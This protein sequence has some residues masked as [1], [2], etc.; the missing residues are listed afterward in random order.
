MRTSL[1]IYENRRKSMKILLKSMKI[2]E[3]LRK[4]LKVGEK[5][6]IYCFPYVFLCFSMQNQKNRTFRGGAAA[7]AGGL[8]RRAKIMPNEK[9]GQKLENLRKS[10]KFYENLRKCRKI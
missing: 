5:K 7:A 8:G 6:K 4:C 1:K 9:I 10:S 2:A 3:N